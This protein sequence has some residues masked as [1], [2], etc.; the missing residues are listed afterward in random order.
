MLRRD[1]TVSLDAIRDA[2]PVFQR[3]SPDQLSLRLTRV[4]EDR[5]FE[6]K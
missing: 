6:M 1:P 2:H 3:M 4:L 5:S